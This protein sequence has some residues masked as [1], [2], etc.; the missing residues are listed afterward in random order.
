MPVRV[1]II[2]KRCPHADDQIRKPQV[3]SAIAK[4]RD[5]LLG[6]SKHKRNLQMIREMF[7]REKALE[8]TSEK[9]L[10]P[11]AVG[12]VLNFGASHL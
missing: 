6:I 9:W 2:C 12:V 7:N 11:I 1:Q 10:T 4:R 8:R 5:L 3:G